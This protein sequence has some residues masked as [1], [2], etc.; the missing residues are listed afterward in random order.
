MNTQ[1]IQVTDSEPARKRVCCNC[2]NNLRMKD[3][4]GMVTHNQCKIDSHYISYVACFE[5]WCPHWRKD[6]KWDE[7]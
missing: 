6:R 1:I 5:H 3:T 7:S 2:G 4:Q